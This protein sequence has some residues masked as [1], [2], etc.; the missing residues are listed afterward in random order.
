[1]YNKKNPQ[2][3]WKRNTNLVCSSLQKF[4]SFF[5]KFI[6]SML[7]FSLIFFLLLFFLSFYSFFSRKKGDNKSNEKN[8]ISL[9]NLCFNIDL[10]RISGWNDLISLKG[11]FGLSLIDLSIRY[12]LIMYCCIVFLFFYFSLVIC[13]LD[14]SWFSPLET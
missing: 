9:Y 7:P 8:T 14:Y 4:F 6:S 5:L 1:M 11:E 12:K 13:Y 2:N 3:G 10:N